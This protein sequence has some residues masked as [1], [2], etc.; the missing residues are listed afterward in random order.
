VTDRFA[1][2]PRARHLPAAALTVALLHAAPAPSHESLDRL[3]FPEATSVRCTVP[4]APADALDLPRALVEPPAPGAGIRH[5]Q[6]PIAS[7][8]T[9][10]PEQDLLARARPDGSGRLR[11]GE[12]GGERMLT[13]E[14]RLQ[15]ALT[16]ILKDYQTPYAAV[17]LIEPAT[18][19]VLAMAEH[20]EGQP[21]L[22]GLS[23]QALFP[24][25][26][27]F[28]LVTA[29][30]LLD[31]GLG[32]DAIGCVHGGKR[33]IQARLL[34]DS[35]ADR[36][37]LTLA[38]AMG[39][40]AN[41]V[42]AKLTHRHL[43]ADQLR[44]A[45]DALHFNR[46][47]DFPVPTDVSLARVPEDPLGLASTGAGFGDVYLSPLHGA[48]LASVAANRGLWR[49]PVLFEDQL[50]DAAAPERVLSEEQAMALVRMMEETVTHGTARRFFR[51]AGLR[52]AVGKTGSLADKP[53]L[54]FRDYT[55]FVGFA[56]RDNPRVAVAA[57]VVNDV[58]WRIHAPWL[59]REAMR[60]V[61]V[62]PDRMHARR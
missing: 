30:A 22:R 15:D 26:S 40:S 44:A 52:D 51:G 2:W 58:R 43:T 56:P 1:P 9:L 50:A 38:E 53:P 10:P 49:A 28:K 59:A 47:F 4:E 8:R 60:L 46:P 61:L 5:L 23:T 45:A 55:W 32:P 48:M 24:A 18:G 35:S 16:R 42:F 41:A 27:V 17:V 29:T 13:V 6:P 12:P 7:A 11:L 62:D 37:C 57:V 36:T 19:R 3:A 25:A 54:P 33:R 31:A 39:R 21:A 14:P 20:A 34:E